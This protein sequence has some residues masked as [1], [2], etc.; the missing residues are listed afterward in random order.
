MAGLGLEQRRHPPPLPRHRRAAAPAAPR[1]PAVPRADAAAS[2][3][4]AA[5]GL[6]D[7]GLALGPA[8]A[9]VVRVWPVTL[10]GRRHRLRAAGR[11]GHG[12]A[13]PHARLLRHG[14]PPRGGGE[15]GAEVRHL[16]RLPGVLGSEH[17]LA[18]AHQEREGGDP[19]LEAHEE[20][21]L[22]KARGLR[23]VLAVL[24]AAVPLVGRLQDT[25]ARGVRPRLRRAVAAGVAER[26]AMLRDVGDLRDPHPGVEDE[27]LQGHRRPA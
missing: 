10:R 27:G 11:R 12:A 14:R 20:A 22:H 18:R 13:A 1:S 26:V 5:V 19:R 24:G 23:H 9:P 16:P 17:V 2:Q 4:L 8:H 6:V 3:A 15:L 25:G 7:A 21:A